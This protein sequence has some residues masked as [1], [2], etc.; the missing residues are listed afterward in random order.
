MSPPR[1]TAESNIRPS[2]HIRAF[3]A[4]SRLEERRD[5]TEAATPPRQAALKEASRMRRI[6]PDK[7]REWT[8]IP[9]S[10]TSKS[11]NSIRSLPIARIEL[12][13]GLTRSCLGTPILSAQYN[14]GTR[15]VDGFQT[16]IDEP[17]PHYCPRRQWGELNC[18]GV[19]RQNP[20]GEVRASSSF[21][22]I[23]GLRPVKN[24]YS[25][26]AERNVTRRQPIDA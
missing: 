12:L 24:Y 21:F 11:S 20:S 3:S 10:V 15:C 4:S 17:E 9:Q 19:V 6:N 23:L 1:A 7:G 13:A 25:F 26:S 8:L 14:S 22:A 2:L 5:R 18:P 16:R